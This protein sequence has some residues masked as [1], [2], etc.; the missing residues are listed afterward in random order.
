MVASEDAVMH[1]S[2]RTG[3]AG[4]AAAMGDLLAD[5]RRWTVREKTAALAML[6]I[7]AAAPA[8]LLGGIP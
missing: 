5:W 8:A 3:R 7:L 6:A 1:Q 2:S 4:L